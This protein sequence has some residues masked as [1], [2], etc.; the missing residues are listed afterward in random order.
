VRRLLD[1]IQRLVE[2]EDKVSVEVDT[3]R[4]LYIYVAIDISI[5]ERCFDVHLLD[6]YVG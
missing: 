5:D 1:A 4:Y 3:F 2:L 6:V